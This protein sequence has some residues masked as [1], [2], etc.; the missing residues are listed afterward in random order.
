MSLL[1]RGRGCVGCAGAVS[2]ADY[3]PADYSWVKPCWGGDGT[4]RGGDPWEAR[5]C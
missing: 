3:S 4:G 2:G 1:C 5:C